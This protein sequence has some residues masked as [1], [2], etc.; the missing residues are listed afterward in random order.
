[1]ENLNAIG[2]PSRFACPECAGVLWEVDGSRPRRYRCHT[3]HGYTLRA[4]ARTHEEA[5]DEA[6]WGA[7]RA[8]Q[9]R[10]ALLREVAEDA[11]AEASGDSAR[12]DAIASAERV[13]RHGE[14]LREMITSD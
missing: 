5:T 6:L 14:Q 9:E 10:E 12:D 7:M 3:G 1:M 2:H 8:L 13:A 4:L 11:D